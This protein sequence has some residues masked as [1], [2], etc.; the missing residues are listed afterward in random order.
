MSYFLF[1]SRILFEIWIYERLSF[2]GWFTLKE[3]QLKMGST[4]SWIP[5]PFQ[6]DGQYMSWWKGI[7]LSHKCLVNNGRA[8][9]IP[10]TPLLYWFCHSLLIMVFQF[11]YAWRLNIRI[12]FIIIYCRRVL[13]ILNTWCETIFD[14]P[15]WVY[16]IYL[17]NGCHAILHLFMWFLHWQFKSG[18]EKIKRTQYV[19]TAI[20]YWVS[21]AKTNLISI[22]RW[23]TD[24]GHV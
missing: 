17:W 4:W 19:C 2:Y 7:I 22:F 12:I 1:I 3:A 14:V 18:M 15:W 9:A 11:V 16:I 10:W 23:H 5:L 13:R 24:L 20:K 8:Q 21:K 6:I